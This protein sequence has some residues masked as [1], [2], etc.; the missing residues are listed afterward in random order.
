MSPEED[1]RLRAAIFAALDDVRW[2]DMD[3]RCERTIRR[4]RGGVYRAIHQGVDAWLTEGDVTA[5]S[6]TLGGDAG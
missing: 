4:Y 6:L 3:E 5:L 1:R 2:P